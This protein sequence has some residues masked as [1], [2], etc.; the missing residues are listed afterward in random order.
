MHDPLDYYRD[1]RLLARFSGASKLGEF[2]AY[3]KIE[4]TAEGR[5]RGYFDLMCGEYVNVPQ[6][7]LV[8]GCRV[9]LPVRDGMVCRIL[10]GERA[11]AEKRSRTHSTTFCVSRLCTSSLSTSPRSTTRLGYTI[12]TYLQTVVSQLARTCPRGS[13]LAAFSITRTTFSSL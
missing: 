5:R 13:G 6:S 12:R 10:V 7:K 1:K 3:Q 11:A 2:T 9:Q 8:Q 4:V